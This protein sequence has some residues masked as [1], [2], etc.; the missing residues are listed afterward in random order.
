MRRSYRILCYFLISIL[1]MA[2]MYTTYVKADSFAQHASSIEASRQY[3]SGGKK[4]AVTQW[5]SSDKGVVKNIDCVVEKVNPVLRSV[6]GNVNGRRSLLRGG[7]RWGYIF[8]CALFVACFIFRCWSIVERFCL[9]EKKY[10]AVLMKYI[11]DMDGKKR[12]ECLI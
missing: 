9:H 2:G 4:V 6:L 7:L 3:L 12:M 10:R 11:H 5:K 1:L 8:L